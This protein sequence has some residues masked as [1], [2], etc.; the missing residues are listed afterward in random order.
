M[1]FSSRRHSRSA[2]RPRAD[3]VVARRL[4]FEAIEDRLMLSAVATPLRSLLPQLDFPSLEII[5]YAAIRGTDSSAIQS[6][7]DGRWAGP[8]A[9]NDGGFITFNLSQSATATNAVRS[10]D[11]GTALRRPAI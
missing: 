6:G 8:G 1:F 5:K 10:N 3:R 4:Q 2:D 7:G 9:S 11:N